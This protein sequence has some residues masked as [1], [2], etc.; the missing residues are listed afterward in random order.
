M[1]SGLF[2]CYMIVLTSYNFSTLTSIS[3]I[4][5]VLPF[6]LLLHGS[7]SSGFSVRIFRIYR[8]L[9]FVPSWYCFQIVLNYA[10]PSLTQSERLVTVFRIFQIFRIFFFFCFFFVFF[11]WRGECDE[12][13]RASPARSLD[14]DTV[15]YFVIVL[16]VFHSLVIVLK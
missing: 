11:F 16:P 2:L 1:F 5:I 15:R 13:S 10:S 6:R 12:M 3:Q 9:N 8:C 4:P 7:L 14:N